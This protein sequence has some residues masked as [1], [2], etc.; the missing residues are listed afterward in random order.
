MKT[1]VLA[2]LLC[3]LA[4]PVSAQTS[5]PAGAPTPEGAAA[6]PPGQ[7]APGYAPPSGYAP[8]PGYAPAPGY[9]NPGYPPYGAWAQPAPVAPPAPVRYVPPSEPAPAPTATTGSERPAGFHMAIGAGF[10]GGNGRPGIG[11]QFKIGAR[12]SADWTLY[13][14]ALN[15]WYRTAPPTTS[16][17]TAAY[18]R[19]AAINGVGVDYFVVPRMGVRFAFGAGVNGPSDWSDSASHPR[20][21]GYSYVM[22]LTCEL[23]EGKSHLSIDPTVHVLQTS[24]TSY[25]GSTAYFL[26]NLNWVWN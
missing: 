8:V 9:A 23:G 19:I 4:L 7:T 10:G 2:V 6:T 12:L 3:C 11:T 14:Y 21:L 25:W 5:A 24:G 26:L 16:S 15:D 1:T 17:G 20:Y 13:Y 18:W 22:G